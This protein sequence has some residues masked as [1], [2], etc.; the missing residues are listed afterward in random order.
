MKGATLEESSV[1]HELLHQIVLDFF[2]SF[3][4]WY[5][6]HQKSGPLRAAMLDCDL[7]IM[8]LA[9]A[10]EN[11]DKRRDDLFCLILEYL[12]SIDNF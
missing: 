8:M 7:I 3:T 9:A 5:R 6:Q 10:V 12:Q 11:R 1:P 2:S 4:V